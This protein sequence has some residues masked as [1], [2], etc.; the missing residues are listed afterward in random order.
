MQRALHWMDEMQ[1]GTKILIVGVGNEEVLSF[2][3]RYGF[4]PKHIT[5]EQ[6]KIREGN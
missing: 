5:V 4:Y 6:V 2:Y 1:A 3:S